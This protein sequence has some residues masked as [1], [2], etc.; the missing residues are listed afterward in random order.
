MNEPA[1]FQNLSA[2]KLFLSF[3]EYSTKVKVLSLE[4]SEVAERIFRF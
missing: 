2:S 4:R 3:A 1:R